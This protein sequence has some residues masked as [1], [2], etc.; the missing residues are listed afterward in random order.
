[1]IVETGL[2]LCAVNLPVA[3]GEIR[4]KGIEDFI[5]RFRN[6]TSLRSSKNTKSSG[7]ENSTGPWK[8]FSKRDDSKVSDIQML[9]DLKKSETY[10]GQGQSFDTLEEGRIHVT[11]TVALDEN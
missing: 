6:F 10:A 9:H 7:Q 2:A 11:R 1:M 8:K 4:H 3:Y 5:K